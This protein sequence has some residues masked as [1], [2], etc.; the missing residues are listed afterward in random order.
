[1]NVA[2]GEAVGL[3]CHHFQHREGLVRRLKELGI[4]LIDRQR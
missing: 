3:I 2:G 1:V 4:E